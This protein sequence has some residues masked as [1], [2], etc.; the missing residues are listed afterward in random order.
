MRFLAWLPGWLGRHRYALMLADAVAIG[1]VGTL[2]VTSL[3]DDGP[4]DLEPG[5]IRI[6]SGLDSSTGRQRQVL[7]DQWNLVHPRNKATIVE[8]PADAD[9]QHAEMVA[10]AQ[11]GEDDIDVYNLDVSWTA[12]FAD[13]GWIR[14]LDETG[15]DLTGFI[16]EPLETCRY[17]GKLWALPFNTDAGLLYYRTDLLATPPGSWKDIRDA[18]DKALGGGSTTGVAA[19]YTAQLAAYEGLTVNALEAAQ[20]VVHGSIVRNGRIDT[21]VVGLDE[22]QEAVDRLRPTAGT[23]QFLLPESLEY[24]E[25]QST[26]AFRDGKVLFMRNWPVAYRNLVQSTAGEPTPGP[27]AAAVPFAV[28]ALPGPGV[29]GGQ[30][31]AIAKNSARP[32]AAQALIEF[33]TGDYS[34][35]ILFDRGGFAATRTIVYED[36]AVRRNHPYAVTLLH[37]IQLAKPR[38]VTPCY[39]KFSEV[40][41]TAVDKALRD[42]ERLPPDIIDTLNAALS[43]C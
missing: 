41:R 7:I 22:L 4:V 31:L 3:T 29:L 21:G 9:A 17:D 38:P 19:G 30:N 15:L 33:L 43:N 24:R 20:S 2:V 42:D 25:D 11:S 23:P 34:E 8:L 32:R 40:F 39:A 14:P 26:E 16:N 35:Q 13:A 10:Q 37:A 36:P 28:T 12:E 6:L 27:A 18:V 5:E 1:I